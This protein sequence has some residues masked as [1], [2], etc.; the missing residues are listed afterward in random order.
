MLHVVRALSQPYPLYVDQTADY[1]I[2]I[3]ATIL[4]KM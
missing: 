2:L 4:L 1:P 3:G